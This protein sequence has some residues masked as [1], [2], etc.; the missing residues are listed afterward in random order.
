MHVYKCKDDFNNKNFYFNNSSALPKNTRNFTM[1]LNEDQLSWNVSGVIP[2]LEDIVDVAEIKR[3][4]SRFSKDQHEKLEKIFQVNP[5]P[6]INTREGLALQFNTLQSSIMNWF[7]KRRANN[8]LD[9]KK[10][11]N[12][13]KNRME[14]YHGLKLNSNVPVEGVEQHVNE[15]SDPVEDVEQQVN[16]VKPKRQVYSSYQTEVLEKFFEENPYPDRDDQQTIAHKLDVEE[17]SVS[18]WF[19]NRRVKSSD[20]P[21]QKRDR[22]PKIDTGDKS[23][24]K[25]KHSP[26]LSRYY[27]RLDKVILEGGSYEFGMPLPDE[28]T[29]SKSLPIEPTAPEYQ[30]EDLLKYAHEHLKPLEGR[31]IS[32]EEHEEYFKDYVRTYTVL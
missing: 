27:A 12:L 2:E 32:F 18:R 10:R 6:D 28:T 21:K 17:K 16:E 11:S 19:S 24:R 14:N 31:M 15:F 23:V 22:K 3:V 7:N 25:H 4:R 9:A 29:A 5:Y 26:D 20:I 13:I 30:T 1:A 8:K